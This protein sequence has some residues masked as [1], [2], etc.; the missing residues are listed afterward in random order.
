MADITLAVIFGEPAE[1]GVEFA[2]VAVV[3]VSGGLALTSLAAADFSAAGAVAACSV[4]T[5]VFADC[6]GP[7]LTLIELGALVAGAGDVGVVLTARSEYTFTAGALAPFEPCADGTFPAPGV[8]IPG[9]TVPCCR[10]PT[11]G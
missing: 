1:L 10:L 3:A 4:L 8:P 7:T 2:G 11:L 5:A 9:N 6:V